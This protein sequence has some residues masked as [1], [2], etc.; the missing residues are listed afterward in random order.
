MGIQITAQWSQLRQQ[1]WLKK[2]K[3]MKLKKALNHK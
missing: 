2:G 3:L 1:G